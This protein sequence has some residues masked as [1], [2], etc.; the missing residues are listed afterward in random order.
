MLGEWINIFL[1]FGTCR[2]L[3]PQL[4]VTILRQGPN[5]KNTNAKIFYQQG[6]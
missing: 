5:A 1:V 3:N 6:E 4:W 2:S